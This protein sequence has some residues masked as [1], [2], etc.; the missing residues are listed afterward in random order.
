M[1][2]YLG[3][4][5]LE[6]DNKTY[7]AERTSPVLIQMLQSGNPLT[8]KAVF[9]VLVQISSY[10][11][12]AKILVE[13][14]IAEIMVEEMFTKKRYS[15][16]VDSL[17]EASAIV[18]NILES[19]HG[20]QN[21]RINNQGHTMDSGYVVFNI[22]YMIKNST[23]DDLNINLIRILSCLTKSSKSMAPVLSAVKESEAS[24]T[25]LELLNN[26]SDEIASAAIKLLTLLSPNIGHVLVDRLCKINGQP[27]GLIQSPSDPTQ[28]TERQALS[29]S[30]LAK[31]PHQNIT[32][33]LALLGKN[34]VPYKKF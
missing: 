14:G 23:R 5:I 16:P 19:G 29:I 9:K 3:E 33:N 7:V 1:A 13:S 25:L 24:Y 34:T 20:F 10:R 21:L 28:I 15:E 17:K 2:T 31:L 4:I 30:F 32:L 27:E 12:N 11:A 26:P 6:D 8:R 22:I 18:A